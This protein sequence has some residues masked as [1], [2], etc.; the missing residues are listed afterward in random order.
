M[1]LWDR[2][3]WTPVRKLEGHKDWVNSIAVDE[4]RGFFCTASDDKTVR[5]WDIKT[6]ECLHVLRGHKEK[7]HSIAIGESQLFV[8]CMSNIY[9][10]DVESWT[11]T[12]RLTNHSH[13]LRAM[14]EGKQ[15]SHAE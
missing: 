8:G 9:V 6:K 2:E 3:S 14:T 11:M 10:W 1:T 15:V 13:V 12:H 5:V 4:K 7:A